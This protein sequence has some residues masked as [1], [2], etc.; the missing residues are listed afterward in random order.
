M[1]RTSYL[2]HSTLFFS[3]LEILL[4][5]RN[6]LTKFSKDSGAVFVQIELTQIELHVQKLQKHSIAHS[7]RR[8]LGEKRQGTMHSIQ[9]HAVYP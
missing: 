8:S 2:D 1:S 5:V 3:F 9:R 6:A 4:S 7:H